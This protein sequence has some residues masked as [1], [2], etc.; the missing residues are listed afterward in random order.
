MSSSDLHDS[1]SESERSKSLSNSRIRIISLRSLA[2]EA[3]LIE[4]PDEPGTLT[5]IPS[6]APAPAK[7]LLPFLLTIPPTARAWI[8]ALGMVLLATLAAAY[9]LSGAPI[10]FVSDRRKSVAPQLIHG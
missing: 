7:H 8:L 9:I 6:S 2:D 5:K 4:W 3:R 1:P 10:P